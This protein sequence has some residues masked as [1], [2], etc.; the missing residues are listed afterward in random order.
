MDQIC[1]DE[2]KQEKNVLVCGLK[3]CSWP[4]AVSSVLTDISVRSEQSDIE[5]GSRY[6]KC[7][8]SITESTRT[9]VTLIKCTCDEHM[10]FA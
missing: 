10:K 5:H 6:C 7:V 4:H 3:V 2:N 1:N 8:G 9:Q